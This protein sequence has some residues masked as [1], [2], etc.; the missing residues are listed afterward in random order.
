MT[1]S[2]AAANALLALFLNATTWADIAEDDTTAPL[3][4]HQH[5]LHTASPGAGGNQT[6]NEVAYTSYE[7][8]AVPRTTSGYAAP[9]SGSAALASLRSF[10]EGSGGGETAAY[11]ALGSATS[12]AGNLYCFGTITPNITTGSGVT[13]QL[14]TS[15]TIS[16]T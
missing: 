11:M 5:S 9:S 1:W 3:T 10:P 6:T 14:T 8:I 16:E 2:T 13:P 7:R 4:N 12:G 15:T